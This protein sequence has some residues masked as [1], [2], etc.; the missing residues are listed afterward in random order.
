MRNFI[1][2]FI[3]AIFFKM[4]KR[5]NFMQSSMKIKYIFRI[6]CTQIEIE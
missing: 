2:V 3:G 6:I 1:H 4:R 5:S